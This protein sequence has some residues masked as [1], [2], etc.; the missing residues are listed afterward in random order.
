MIKTIFSIFF[1]TFALFVFVDVSTVWYA[2]TAIGK[3]MAQAVDAGLIRGGIQEDLRTGY[4]RLDLDL[5]RS[6]VRDTIQTNLKLNNQLESKGYTNSSL[7]TDLKYFNN[8]PRLEAE[9][10]THVTLVAGRLVG[11][12]SYP[13]TV[14]KKT[15]YLAI[16]K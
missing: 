16:Y 5:A 1:A 10:K 7:Q 13:V 4:A 8:Q 6:A 15:P 11:L 9:F 3:T 12:S 14:T 2:Y